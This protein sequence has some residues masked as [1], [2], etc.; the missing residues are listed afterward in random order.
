M[1]ET[2]SFGNYILVY[3]GQIY[4]TKELTKELKQNYFEI[5][6]HSDTEI[7]L[8]GYILY[9]KDVINHLN[10]IFAFAVLDTSKKELFLARDHF[11]VKPLFYTNV[12]DTL[13]FASELRTAK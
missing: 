3:N 7:L 13:I 9:G 4:N 8:K 6:T 2:F 1:I 11:G 5:R 12:D 10:G